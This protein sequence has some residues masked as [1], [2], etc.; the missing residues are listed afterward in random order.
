MEHALS[1]RCRAALIGVALALLASLPAAAGLRDEVE[2]LIARAN[3]SGAT[4][5]VSVRDAET[6]TVLIAENDQQLMI[7]ASNMKLLTTGAALH[8]LGPRFEFRTRLLVDGDRL[9]IVGDGDP[10]FGDPVLLELMQVGD[11]PGLGVDEF[12][13]LWVS[14]VQAAGIEH[15]SSIT[16]DDRIFDRNFI[17]PGW[18]VDQLNRSYCAE[19]C[20]FNFHG[21]VLNFY[22]RPGRGRRPDLSLFQPYAPWLVVTNRAT[23]RSGVHDRNDVWIA[24][25]RDT[26]ELTF[27][28]NVKFPYRTP[29][30]VTVHDIPAFFAQLFA[31]R[32]TDA[33]IG[34]DAWGVEVDQ[35]APPASGRTLAPVVATP[36]SAVV[37]RCN[38]DSQNLY[39]ESLLKRIGFALTN[40]PG[41]WVNGSAVIRLV[42]HDR[43]DNPNLAVLLVVRDGSGLSRDNRVAATTITAW[44]NTFHND[45]RIGEIFINSL[46]VAGSTGTLANRFRDVDL[47]GT[48]VQAKSG[49]VR[50]VSCLSGYLTAPDRR[51]R[52]FS[53]L[54]NEL[55]QPGAVPEAKRL[56][57][58]ILSAVA[59]DM[60]ASVSVM[61][62]E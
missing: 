52:S 55:Q 5:A 9:V 7:P 26:N 42:V 17:H 33:G 59:W 25:R 2:T 44:L 51:R 24:R 21:N 28:G 35:S 6:G 50:A 31:S 62:G 47:H 19:V 40:E 30:P 15:V 16:V 14:A 20:G 61:G 56:Q 32:L 12:L 38:R 57:E 58:R 3:L 29:A 46:A 45:P 36:I 1:R 43:L 4:V 48:I 27:F 8:V 37:A 13:Q 49:Y 23:S 60:T 53:I 34:V 10:G 11:R 18:P 41:S 54:I 22:P 39:A